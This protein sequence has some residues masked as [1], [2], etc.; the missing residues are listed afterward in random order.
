MAA[1]T[2]T[3]IGSLLN[4]SKIDP[5]KVLPPLSIVIEMNR[6]QYL[7]DKA[8]E[9]IYQAQH[10]LMALTDPGEEYNDRM[11]QAIT[12]LTIARAQRDL[13]N[14]AAKAKPKKRARSNNTVGHQDVPGTP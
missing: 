12:L 1:L 7:E 2:K 11:V 5:K 6:P 3:L 10:A 8:I 14:G 13:K 9:L 4:Q